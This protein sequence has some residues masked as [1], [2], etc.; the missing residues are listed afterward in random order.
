MSEG[1]RLISRGTVLVDPRAAVA[2]LRSY[3]LAEPVMYVLELVRAAVAGG[4]TRIELYN[5]ADDFMLTFDGDAPD[6]DELARLLDF[7]LSDAEHRLR[8]VAIAVNTAL[9]FSPSY[10][11][12]Y[13]TRFEHMPAD[14]AS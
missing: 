13:T 8:L 10:V 4:A 5:D 3:Q 1:R 12:L 2:K 7:L 11:D 14:G 6:A 9:G